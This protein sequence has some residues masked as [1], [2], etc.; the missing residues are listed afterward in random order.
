M[1]DID[2]CFLMHV[3]DVC[4]E[5]LPPHSIATQGLVF[6]LED[7]F[8]ITITLLLITSHVEV[9]NELMFQIFP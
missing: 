5:I 3:G 8:K 4:L 9:V 7:L 6:F 2:G 1:K